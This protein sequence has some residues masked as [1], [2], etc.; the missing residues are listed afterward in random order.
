MKSSVVSISGL[1]LLTGEQG[2]MHGLLEVSL[3]MVF[4]CNPFRFCFGCM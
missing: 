4:F 1:I 2:D 3:L